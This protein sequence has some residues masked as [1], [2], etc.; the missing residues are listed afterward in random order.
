[1]E[2]PAQCKQ[3]KVQIYRSCILAQVTAELGVQHRCS[4]AYHPESHGALERFYQTLKTMFGPYVFEHSRY[5]AQGIPFL[6]FAV[7]DS[8]QESVGFSPFKLVFGHKVRG[9]L[10]LLRDRILDKPDSKTPTEG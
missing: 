5:W 7:R 4:S 9:P 8:V 6:L 1:M 3:P 10:T 2:F